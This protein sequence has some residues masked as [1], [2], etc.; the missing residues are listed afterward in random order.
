VRVW[1]RRRPRRAARERTRLEVTTERRRYA[2]G[3]TVRGEVVAAESG[4]E[5]NVALNFH[6]RSTEYEAVTITV[7]GRIHQPAE[8]GSR[9]RGRFEIELP[10]D[11][12]PAYVSAHG[13]LWWAVDASAGEPGSGEV[14]TTRIEVGVL[15]VGVPG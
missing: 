8:P 10:R 1:P 6:E 2:P 12:P 15:E 14:A 3:E 7:P 4:G 11:A 9:E 13:E 5:I